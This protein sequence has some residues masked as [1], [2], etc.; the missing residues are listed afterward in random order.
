VKKAF[1]YRLYPTRKQADTLQF[2]LDRNRELYNASLEE[3]KEAYRMSKMSISYEDQSAQLPEIK[4]IRPE[5]KEIYSQVLQ[6]TLKRVDKAFKAFFKRCKEGKTPGFPRFHGYDRYNSFTYPQIEKL[7]GKPTVAIENGKIIL[8]KIGHIKVKQHRPLEGRGKTCTIKREGDCWFVVF[9]CEVEAQSRLPD[10]DLA[11]GID[12]GLKHFMTDSHGDTVE[13]PRSFRKSRGR[14]KKLQQ[15]LCKKKKKSN[16]RR[17]AVKLVAKAHKKIRNQRK[18]FHHKESRILV[19]TFETIV[20]EDLSRHNMV[21]KPKPKQD[22]NGKYLPNGASAKAGLNQSILDAGWGN[23]IE[24]VKHKAECAG[25]TVYEVNP[26]K[27]SQIC[28]ACHKEGEHKD[29]SIRTHV[30]VYCGVVLD[31][32]HNAA[33]N[34]LD[35]GLG[36]SLRE[37]VSPGTFRGALA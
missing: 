33:L 24:L 37:P 18:D 10:T 14:L 22:E 21:R 31:R 15:R 20:F 17:K 16:R 3:R 36:R 26:Q 23:F 13:H 4:E 35:R 6:D 32:D 5:Y 34:I 7:K 8:P 25:V 19:D 11:I 30:C 12:M 2:T 9:V 27:T 1:T 29:L 28:S